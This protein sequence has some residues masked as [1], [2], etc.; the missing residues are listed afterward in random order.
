MLSATILSFLQT[1]A[2]GVAAKAIVQGN[3]TAADD[4]LQWLEENLSPQ[5]VISCKG[6]PL[7]LFNAGRY[8]GTQFG[9]N[10]SVVVFPVSAQDVSYTVQATQKTS[11]SQEFAFASGAHSMIN[12]SSS[13]EFVIDLIY[14]NKTEVVHSF[15]AGNGTRVT[16]IS[17]QGGADWGQ[18]I[19]AVNG[20]GY[21]PVSAR[22]SNVGVGG[23]STGGGIG[24]LAG[25]YGY[26]IDRLLQLEVVLASGEIV[27]ATKYNAYSDLF[28]ALQ[29]GTGQFGIVTT[30]WQEA[31]P[32]PPSSTIG[33]YYINEEDIDT[34]RK[35]TVDFFD[36]N[37]DPF[38][39]MY[40]FIGFVPP[41]VTETDPST[42]G[43]RTLIAALHFNDPLTPSQLTYNETFA[44][45]FS[46]INTTNH[47]LYTLPYAN[48][49]DIADPFFPYGFRRGFYGPQVSSITVDYLANISS[50]MSSYISEIVARGE[51]PA[52]AGHVTQ[53][54]F[55]GLNGH[56][57]KTD[58]ATGWPHTIGGHQSLFSPAWTK[59][60]DDGFMFDTNAFLN[61]ISYDRQEEE[62]DYIPDYPN[63]ISPGVT[64]KRVWGDN[65]ERLIEVKE[66][67]D[68]ECRI[69]VGRV[70]ASPGCLERGYANVF[71]G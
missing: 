11:F 38:S 46:G 2:I 14:L 68:P 28:W 5:A 49:F 19:T 69:H 26:A 39:L 35:N 57:P 21:I 22:A 40:Y 34:A 61:Q 25:A 27:I 71:A 45:L 23:F 67:Y 70:F 8:W 47:V 56:L 16:A 1:F 53:Y 66:K 48:I 29:G 42:F 17:Y 15:D 58:D 20:S 4:G 51:V 6:E 43:T 41:S 36:T 62:G 30:F 31:S 63:Y 18:V 50:T 65:V 10:A 54:M 55:P 44:K 32:T 33:Y 37:T 12:A 7:Q 59:A 3:C 60:E 13:D 64:G 52:T 24:F 9:K